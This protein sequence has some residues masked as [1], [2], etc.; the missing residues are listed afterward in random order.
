MFQL[1]INGQT[2]KKTVTPQLFFCD[3]RDPL[4][5]A[6]HKIQPQ[7]MRLS[8][9]QF[10]FFS[11]QRYKEYFWRHFFHLLS[12]HPHFHSKKKKLLNTQHESYHWSIVI[13]SSVLIAILPRKAEATTGVC[14]VAA[15]GA[16][17]C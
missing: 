9:G 8:F 2:L 12:N 16:L 14:T 10:F 7:N 11:A 15:G 13:T 4:K 6:S 17:R 3:T 1:N 5:E